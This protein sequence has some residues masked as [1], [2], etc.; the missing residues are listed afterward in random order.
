[1][2]GRYPE[3]RERLRSVKEYSIKNLPKL[4]EQAVQALEGNGCKVFIANT[5]EEARQYIGRIVEKGLVVKSKSNAGKEIEITKHL[6]GQGAQ[7]IETDLGDRINQLAKSGAS[8]SLAPAIHIPIER[9]TELFSKEAGQELECD[10]DA[11]VRAARKSL[12]KYL[13]EADVGI[14]GAN[15]VVAE[16]GSIFLTENEGNIRA[17]TSMPRI[18]IAIA[19]VEKI[20]PE[21]NDG[22]TVIKAAAAFGVGQDIGTYVSVISGPSKYTPADLEFLGHGQ[23]PEEVHVVFLKG[24]RDAAIQEG[25]EESLY[26]INCG[27]CLNFC[28]VYAEIGDKYGYKYL[29]G[30]GTVF[31]AFHADLDKAQEAG[32]FLCIGCQK[33]LE[34]CAVRMNTPEMISRLRAKVVNEE[35]LSWT[36]KQVFN[37]LAENKLSKYLKLARTFQDIALKRSPEGK[38][39]TL[40]VSMETLG[41]PSSRLVPTLAGQTFREMVK[42]KGRRVIEKPILR[43]GFFAGCMVNYVQPELG[44][45]LLDLLGVQGIE[46]LI[47]AE[48]G[49]CGLP[50]LMSGAT[51]E[52]KVVAKHNINLWTKDTFDYLLFV[53]PSCATTVKKEWGNLLEKDK[54]E[55]AE[56]HQKLSPKVMDATQFLVDVLKLNIS[57]QGLKRK[58]TYHDPCHL[59]RGLAVKE[60]PRKILQSIPGVEYVEMEDADSCCGFGG[61]FSLFYYDLAKRINAE[62]INKIKATNAD[63]VV[64]SCPGC[65]MHIRDGIHH[66]GSKQKVVHTVQLVAEALRGGDK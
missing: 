2:V 33:C 62:K 36:K 61:S 19:G 23:G 20:V 51:E 63:Y 42:A 21:L 46:V 56:K 29:G 34:S 55:L 14:S 22:I 3:L 11:L 66:A 40:R 37:I 9:V 12:R 54:D 8:H 53:C 31:S 49:C 13:E 16:T 30:R 7:V 38:T 1:M 58:V 45:D 24:G 35:G 26:C 50:M 25:F 60:Q 28:P 64:T 15:A 44:L 65:M 18:H 47:Y 43:V 4:L 39:A 59:V 6:E 5:P 52:A 41:M 10:P 48:E 57:M 27:S 32:L 17:V